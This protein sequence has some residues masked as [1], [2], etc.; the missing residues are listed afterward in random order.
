VIG[1]SKVCGSAQRRQRGAI[2][3]HGA[4]LLAASPFTPSLPG[5]LELTGVAVPPHDL[6]VGLA[7]RARDELGWRL[8]LEDWTDE[9]QALIRELAE[10]RYR[11]DAWNRKR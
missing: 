3:Q 6:R 9:E 1:G 7:L 10:S 11:T 4:I 2:L 8:T 5:V